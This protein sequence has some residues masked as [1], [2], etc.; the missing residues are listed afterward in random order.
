MG[1]KN[2]SDLLL[3]RE[4]PQELPDLSLA[5][6]VEFLRRLVQEKDLRV[7]GEHAAQFQ[8]LP[9]PGGEAPDRP[10]GMGR[11]AQTGEPVLQVRSGIPVRTALEPGEKAE[12]LHRS[13]ER[14]GQLRAFTD[15]ADNGA[16][17]ERLPPDIESAHRGGPARRTEDRGQHLHGRSLARTVASEETEHGAFGDPE[18]KL[19]DGSNSVVRSGYADRFDDG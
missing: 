5:R 18:G 2:E 15:D 11:E 12:V 19:V 16:D 7:T 14:P 17:L 3:C 8:P 1:A 4:L 9:H 10:S 13:P 6:D